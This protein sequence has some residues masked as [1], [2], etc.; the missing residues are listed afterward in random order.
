MGVGVNL[1]LLKKEN[2]YGDPYFFFFFLKSISIEHDIKAKFKDVQCDFF[3]YIIYYK[4]KSDFWRITK[5]TMQFLVT[6]WY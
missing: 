3:K 6:A 5:Y 1:A 2:S 4:N